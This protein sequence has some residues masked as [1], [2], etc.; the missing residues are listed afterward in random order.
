HQCE[1]ITED[2]RREIKLRA[3]KSRKA[4]K[5]LDENTSAIF[6][7]RHIKAEFN[8]NSVKEYTHN[9]TDTDSVYDSKSY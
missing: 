6:K 1:L 9:Q 3:K 2:H 4:I 7:H 5:A 8:I